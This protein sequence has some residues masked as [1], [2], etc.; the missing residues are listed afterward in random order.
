M[1]RVSN[2]EQVVKLF[3]NKDLYPFIGILNDH[4]LLKVENRLCII[5]IIDRKSLPS[6]SS[7]IKCSLFEKE[8]WLQCHHFLFP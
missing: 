3:I 8:K 7:D 1:Y 4:L 2:G 6:R 5:K